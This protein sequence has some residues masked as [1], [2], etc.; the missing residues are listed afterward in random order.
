MLYQRGSAGPDVTRI[1]QKLKDLNLYLGPLDG[2]FGGGTEA[3]VKAFQR[4][5]GLKPDGVVGDITW[6]RLFPQQTM[7]AC[8]LLAE[9][10]NVRCLALTGCFENTC[11]VPDCYSGLSGDFDGQGISFGALQWNLGQG[12]LQP[13]LKKMIAGHRAVAEQVFQDHLP[14]LEAALAKPRDQQLAW[15]RSIQDMQKFRLYEPWRGMF[16]ALGRTPEFQEIECQEV[17]ALYKRALDMCDEYRLTTERGAALMFDICT[18]NG[19]IDKTVKAQILAD[20]TRISP[21]LDAQAAEIERMRIIAN[22]RAAV[23]RSEYVEDVRRRKLTIAEGKG[24]V[25]GLNYDL[26]SQFAIRLQPFAAA[27][28]AGSLRG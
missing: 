6:A 11:G 26:E 19:S 5:G 24:T 20:Y 25:H 1:Q 16:K 22:R 7:P 15:A 27:T 18:Q 17:A 4:A 8:A 14:E 12:S 21:A 3:A 9:P 23:C 13:M 2:S 10:V 28:V